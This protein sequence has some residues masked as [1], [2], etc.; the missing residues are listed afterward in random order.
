MSHEHGSF[1]DPEM[2]MVTK[3]IAT[4]LLH[5]ASVQEPLI[6]ILFAAVPAGLSSFWR[7]PWAEKAPP[8]TSRSAASLT[9]PQPA[10]DLRCQPDHPPRTSLVVPTP[11]L[12]QTLSADLDILP[13]RVLQS[14]CS[15]DRLVDVLL[16]DL[17]DQELLQ[18]NIG[19]L[20]I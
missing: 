14:C 10:T 1:L 11:C 19:L 8:I 17:A 4:G 9:L 20:S 13:S 2:R 7:Q 15:F 5:D 3:H 18:S 12:G 6:S 16:S